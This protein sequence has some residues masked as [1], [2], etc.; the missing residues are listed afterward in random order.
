MN[1]LFLILQR[2]TN[3]IELVEAPERSEGFINPYIDNQSIYF[4]D[5]EIVYYYDNLRD[6]TEDID[7]IID[8]VIKTTGKYLTFDNIE[9]CQN[10]LKQNLG[11]RFIFMTER[12]IT[13]GV[14]ERFRLFTYDSKLM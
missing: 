9:K 11:A 14:V 3:F 8:E 13:K 1:K 7:S 5:N 2:S 12:T 10:F 6:W 4:Y